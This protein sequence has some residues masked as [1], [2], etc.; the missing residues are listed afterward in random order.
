MQKKIDQMEGWRIKPGGRVIEHIAQFLQGP[1]KIILIW[2][3]QAEILPEELG[4]VG[5]RRLLDVRIFGD[6]I[7]V[8]PDEII[9]EWIRVDA[10]SD[11]A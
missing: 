5:K 4:R 7:F 9:L 10:D 8:V 6:E 1:V 3:V 11:C 2:A